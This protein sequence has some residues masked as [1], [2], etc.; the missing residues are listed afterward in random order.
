MPVL[1]TT[2]A[3]L[4]AFVATRAL[5]A[6][7][8][9]EVHGL[10]TSRI[11]SQRWTIGSRVNKSLLQAEVLLLCDGDRLVERGQLDAE[12]MS[13]NWPIVQA[14]DKRS[15]LRLFVNRVLNDR[16]ESARNRACWV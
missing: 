7:D 16:I 2:V 11:L 6:L 10:G 8:I 3:F 9:R 12:Q 13:L 5:V 14:L 15:D 1:L 4:R